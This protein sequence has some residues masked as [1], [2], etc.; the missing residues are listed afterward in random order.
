[1]LPSRKESILR[2]IFIESH[3]ADLLILMNVFHVIFQ[4]LALVGAMGLFIFGVLIIS[5]MMQKPVGLIMRNITAIINSETSKSILT[6]FVIT[7]IIHTLLANTVRL[8]G[9]VL[10]FMNTSFSRVEDNRN[11]L[12]NCGFK[13]LYVYDA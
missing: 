1:M 5:E 12:L 2:T 10:L 3:Y 7:S 8:A 4:V 11:T 6:G 13:G 9:F